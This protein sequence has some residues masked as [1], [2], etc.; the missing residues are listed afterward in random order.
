MN[1]D[2]AWLY[3]KVGAKICLQVMGFAR[4]WIIREL[5]GTFLGEDISGIPRVSRNESGASVPR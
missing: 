2:C 5:M 3:R 1:F 4:A